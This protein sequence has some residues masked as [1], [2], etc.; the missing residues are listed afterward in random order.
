MASTQPGERIT[1]RKLIWVGPLTLIATVIA[2]L[3]IRT[4]AVLIFGVPETFQFLQAPSVI[5]STIVFLL[6]A[7]LVFGLVNR[8][9]RRPIRFYRILALVLL[10]ISFLT[11]IMALTGQIPAPGMNLSIFWTMI[12]MH[13]VSAIVIVGLLTTLA[14]EQA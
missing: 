5:G 6:A 13:G 4:V 10:C 1:L 9:A 3:V 11:P 2:N 8:F 14:R 7:L 12:V